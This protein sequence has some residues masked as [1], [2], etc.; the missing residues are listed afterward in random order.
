[1]SDTMTPEETFTVVETADAA[2]VLLTLTGEFDQNG[3]HRAF[4]PILPRLLALAVPITLDLTAVGYID[5]AGLADVIGLYRKLKAAGRALTVRL[6]REGQVSHVF[7]ISQIDRLFPCQR[8]ALKTVG[9]TL[10]D[11]EAET[12]EAQFNV[13]ALQGG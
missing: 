2:G 12:D 9:E 1:M 7:E 5:S 6:R 11:A 10:R 8:P 4:R 3:A 13:G